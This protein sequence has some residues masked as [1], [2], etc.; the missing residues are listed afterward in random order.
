MQE[1]GH[2]SP[3]QVPNVIFLSVINL[4]DHWRVAIKREPLRGNEDV[5]L[6]VLLYC[7]VEAIT[8]PT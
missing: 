4:T 8:L 3:K 6:T 2:L 5:L 1:N 7:D